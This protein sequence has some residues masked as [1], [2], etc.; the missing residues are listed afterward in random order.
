MRP[1]QAG[2][3]E[4]TPLGTPASPYFVVL[5]SECCLMSFDSCDCALCLACLAIFHTF[6]A[7]RARKRATAKKDRKPAL[8][9]SKKAHKTYKDCSFT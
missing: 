2:T 9:L 6:T 5:A 4:G 8:L 3:H 7:Y 1:Q